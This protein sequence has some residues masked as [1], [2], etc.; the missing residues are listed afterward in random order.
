MPESVPLLMDITYRCKNCGFLCTLKNIS[1]WNTP[2]VRVGDYGSNG[3]PTPAEYVEEMHSSSEIEFWSGGDAAENHFIYSDPS[4]F[5]TGSVGK[6]GTATA[7]AYTWPSA[8]TVNAL[9]MTLPGSG[10][11]RLNLTFTPPSGTIGPWTFSQYC[12]VTG[13]TEPVLYDADAAVSDVWISA[14]EGAT[15]RTVTNTIEEIGGGVYMIS[16]V[17]TTVTGDP[18]TVRIQ[19]SST[20]NSNQVWLSRFQAN[21]GSATHRYLRTTGSVVTVAAEPAR[22]VET[23]PN[24]FVDSRILSG[25]N[26]RVATTSGTNDGDYTIAD[27]G[28]KRGEILLV[29]TDSLTDELAGYAGTTTISRV[30]AQPSITTGCPFCGTL[31][32]R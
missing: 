16:S 10:Y 20:F 11:N 28:M 18:I 3:T 30:I 32:S 13:D 1:G 24:G 27:P 21:P 14:V 17:L 23:A 31:N 9:S 7:G 4:A 15:T 25:M 5:V 8:T 29:S 2:V 12:R 19:K 22:I 26:I 6:T